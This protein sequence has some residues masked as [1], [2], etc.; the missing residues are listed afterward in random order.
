MASDA[1][2]RIKRLMTGDP[3]DH[4]HFPGVLFRPEEIQDG[5]APQDAVIVQG[6]QQKFGFH[7]RRLE[8]SRPEVSKIIKEVVQDVFLQSKG[9]G[10]SF[11]NLCMDRNDNQWAEHQTM[12]EFCC[13]AIGL[14]LA[15]WCVPKEMW[16]MFPGGMPYIW[17]EG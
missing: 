1:A 11:L 7:P 16:G 3:N 12:D 5:E 10:M 6:I 13:L 8:Q 14:K 2:Y 15:D 9:G 17:F 4:E